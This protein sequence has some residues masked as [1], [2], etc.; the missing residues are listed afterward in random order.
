MFDSDVIKGIIAGWLRTLLTPVIAYIAA[1]GWLGESDAV[2]LVA[3]AA[4]LVVA[5]AW[6]FISKLWQ[7]DK[8]LTALEMPPG[9]S[10]EKLMAEMKGE[11]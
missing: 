7:N 9:S 8:V 10:K 5:I 4:S 1:Q 3:I 2:K 11:V 6:S